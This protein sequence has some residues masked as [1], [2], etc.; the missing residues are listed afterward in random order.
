[1]LRYFVALLTTLACMTADPAIAIQ[2][3]MLSS[4]SDRALTAEVNDDQGL[5]V[6]GAAVSFQLSDKTVKAETKADGRVSIYA[7]QLSPAQGS[8]DIRVTAVKDH[9][10]AGLITHQIFAAA[11]IAPAATPSPTAKLEPPKSEP[12][13]P[14]TAG[15]DGDFKNG[16]SFHWRWLALLG[17][18]AGAGAGFY[19]KAQPN[20]TVTLSSPLLAAPQVGTPS[21]TIGH[22]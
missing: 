6:S 7:T 3:R 17:L 20:S 9:A 1:M 16:H 8:Y 11:P 19:L 15:G 13:M 2:I 21:I 14:V 12:V 18:V 10:R 4:E 5:P 22:P